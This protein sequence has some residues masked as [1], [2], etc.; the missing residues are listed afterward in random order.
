VRR[1]PEETRRFEATY[2]TDSPPQYYIHVVYRTPP[3]L[4]RLNSY[5]SF[6]CDPKIPPFI[7]DVVPRPAAT[8]ATSNLHS[9]KFP[10]ASRCTSLLHGVDFMP[11]RVYLIENFRRRLTATALHVNLLLNP[12]RLRS[13]D[14]PSPQIQR[15]P[16]YLH[17]Q[18]TPLASSGEINIRL[19]STTRSRRCST[20]N[21]RLPLSLNTLLSRVKVD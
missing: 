21:T 1:N 12:P 4:V 11:L 2:T 15:R 7:V 17:T 18:A 13:L 14:F 8:N 5:P 9:M 20:K 6:P 10:A 16:F 19:H 3:P